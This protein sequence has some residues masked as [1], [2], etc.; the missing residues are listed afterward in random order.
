ML[1]GL[2]CH[3]GPRPFLQLIRTETPAGNAALDLAALHGSATL[4]DEIR[5]AKDAA[6]GTRKGR[7]VQVNRE[8][9]VV[10]LV[11]FVWVADTRAP[12]LG[13]RSVRTCGEPSETDPSTANPML[14]MLVML[15]PGPCR[16]AVWGG[17]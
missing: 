10:F 14:V 4:A 5:T 11:T 13:V 16:H 8:C 15:A 9:R 17:A 7:A 12:P 3:T 1:N 2:P 6:H